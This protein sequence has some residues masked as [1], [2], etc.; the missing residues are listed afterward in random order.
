MPW[1]ITFITV[2]PLVGTLVDR[3]GERPFMVG[4]LTCRR[5]GWA[6]SR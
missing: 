6:G 1:T 5:S 3:F 2:A 4:G